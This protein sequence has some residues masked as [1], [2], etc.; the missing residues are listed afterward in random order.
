MCVRIEIIYLGKIVEQ[1]PTDRTFNSPIHPYTK[2]LLETA[3][4]LDKCR[5]GDSTEITGSNHP[6]RQCA[7]GLRLSHPLPICDGNLRG[8]HA[9]TPSGFPRPRG[10]L[11]LDR[12]PGSQSGEL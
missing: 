8:R 5:A 9:T 3:P 11:P 10:S 2:V 12:D 4:T 7:L 1:A 6:I